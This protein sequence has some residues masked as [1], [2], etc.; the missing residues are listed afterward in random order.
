[1]AKQTVELDKVFD[2]LKNP[3]D[4]VDDEEWEKLTDNEKREEIL[5]CYGARDIFE[6]K[7]NK[8]IARYEYTAQDEKDNHLIVDW[9]NTY[10]SS[11]AK[12]LIDFEEEHE[13]PNKAAAEA[14][15]ALVNELI[16]SC[17]QLAKMLLNEKK[18]K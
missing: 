3:W 12:I 13:D 8:N 2:G 18:T 10:S 9:F 17:E 6:Y 4:D 16:D 7:R 15:I 1:M 14:S 5:D 11:I